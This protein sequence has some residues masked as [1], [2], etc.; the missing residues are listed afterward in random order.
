MIRH[1][2][3]RPLLNRKGLR[4]SDGGDRVRSDAFDG[5]AAPRPA[6]PITRLL[7]PGVA[8]RPTQIRLLEDLHQV[9]GNAYVQRAL[10]EARSATGGPREAQMGP[11]TERASSDTDQV[12]EAL[13]PTTGAGPA[14]AVQRAGP[15]DS[16]EKGL[17][18]ID[19]NPI[20]PNVNKL[21]EAAAQISTVAATMEKEGTHW[22]GDDKETITC[23][24]N[25]VDTAQKITDAA[26]GFEKMVLSVKDGVL[27]GPAEVLDKAATL[28]RAVDVAASIA[29]NQATLDAM[30]ER[31]SDF[32]AAATWAT[33][34]G[35]TFDKASELIP[36]SIGGLP[37]FIPQYLKGLLAAPSNYIQV[38][39][40]LQRDRIRGVESATG[41]TQAGLSTKDS[42]GGT[43]TWKGP[44]SFVFMVAQAVEPPGL[45]EFMATHREI[46]GYDLFETSENLGR[47]LLRSAIEK[48]I[49]DYQKRKLWTDWLKAP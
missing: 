31:P 40:A 24:A 29:E 12:E 19:L 30:R 15:A 46:R 34:I 35:N 22:Y 4:R 27:E 45:Q 26:S 37:G 25:M 28:M 42:S 16:T 5:G 14:P 3:K 33:S 8:D 20:L 11:V 21:K 9:Q 43:T 2:A 38:F 36:D 49:T 44:L 23:A 18:S 6:P 1:G 47:A 32:E 39:I 41:G 17:N 10:A 7:A 13:L 48:E